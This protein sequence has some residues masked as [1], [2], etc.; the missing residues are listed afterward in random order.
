MHTG[1]WLP[2]GDLSY[3]QTAKATRWEADPRGVHVAGQPEPF[4]GEVA[5]R[6]AAPN[7]KGATD[8]RL[9]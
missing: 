6:R 2:K 8:R 4:G 5:R 7:R 9:S 3:G 1:A